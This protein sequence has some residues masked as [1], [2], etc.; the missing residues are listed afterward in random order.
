MSLDYQQGSVPSSKPAGHTQNRQCRRSSSASNMPRPYAYSKHVKLWHSTL[1]EKKHIRDILTQTKIFLCH[2]SDTFITKIP[3]KTC[4][5]ILA[6]AGSSYRFQPPLSLH[7]LTP[8]M[9]PL[10]SDML[11]IQRTRTLLST[12]SLTSPRWR[13]FDLGFMKHDFWRW[14]HDFHIWWKEIQNS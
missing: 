6:E 13:E 2:E 5:V 4:T 9:S 3:M 11:L 10:V 8:G 1:Q 7:P 12:K 14:K